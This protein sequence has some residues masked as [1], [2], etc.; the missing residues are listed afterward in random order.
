MK[1]PALIILAC[2][3]Y[4]DGIQAQKPESLP[5]PLTLEYVLNMPAHMSPTFMRQ[6]A[7]LLQLQS[8]QMQV[9][10]QD[11]LNVDLQGR[12]GKREFFNEA[13]DYNRAVLHLGV[14]L[15]DAGRAD[16]DVQAWSLDAKASEYRLRSIEQQFRLDLMRAYFN[17]LLADLR[18]RIDNEAM[19]IAYVTLDKIRDAH[20]LGLASD[21]ELYES[22][23]KYQKALLKRQRAL[24]DLRRLPML[25]IN[26]MGYPNSELPDL[27][28]PQLSV[29]PA[30]LS[31]LEHYLNLA[32][33]NNPNILAAKQAYNASQHRVASAQAEDGP[34][35]RADAWLG[36]LSSYPEVREGNWHAEIS[37]NIPLY[38]GGLGKSRVDRERA[39]GLK[40][41]ADIFDIEQQVRQQVI[42]LYFQLEL[43]AVKKKVVAS[44]QTSADFN[45]DYKRALYENE[46]QTDL[47]DA[48]VRISQTH[49]DALEF[50]LNSALLWAKMQALTG[51]ENLAE[52]TGQKLE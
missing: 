25:L 23:E 10:A 31:E 17:V 27:K 14:P 29:P 52:Q 48:M 37:V 41:R 22:E 15:Y 44:S 24:A 13:Q 36:Q 51:V 30:S 7:S 33:N 49:Y 34:A 9:T 40:D 43:L 8:Q 38:D 50:D 20:E 18:Y 39:Q 21:T 35:I 46:Q 3:I 2:L 19:A 11:G 12:L 5:T 47:G 45:L 4:A 32:L 16:S 26:A 6:Q 42:D 28:L 1:R